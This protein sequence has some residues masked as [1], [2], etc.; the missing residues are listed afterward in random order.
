MCKNT[1]HMKFHIIHVNFFDN[2]FIKYVR[3]HVLKKKQRFLIKKL[4][5][6]IKFILRK[7][8]KVTKFMK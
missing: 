6:T 5:Y 7:Y 3:N 8:V 1:S 2:I 4:K